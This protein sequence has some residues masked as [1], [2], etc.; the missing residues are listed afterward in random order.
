MEEA[1]TLEFNFLYV[2]VSEYGYHFLD[3]FMN[4]EKFSKI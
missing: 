2:K 4:L 1:G 3:L